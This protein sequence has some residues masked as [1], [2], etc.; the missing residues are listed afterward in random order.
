MKKLIGFSVFFSL[1]IALSSCNER[2]MIPLDQALNAATGQNITVDAKTKIDILFVVDASQSMKKEQESLAENFDTFS[3]FIFE[4]LKNAV[5]YRIAVVSTGQRDE[6]DPFGVFPKDLGAFVNPSLGQRAECQNSTNQILSPTNL[7]CDI[8]DAD[9]QRTQ[10][11]A[12]F[13]C[14]AQVGIEGVGFERGLEAMRSALSCNGL[15]AN[16]LGACC[17]FDKSTDSFV[18][19]PLCRG[20]KDS[21]QPSPEFLRPDAFLVVVFITDEDDCSTFSDANA[22]SPYATC[23]QDY[24]TV[25]DL[26]GS[27]NTAELQAANALIYSAYSN[28]RYCGGN[29]PEACHAAECTNNDGQVFDPVECYFK[30]CSLVL[31]TDSQGR[32]DPSSKEACRRQADKLAPV[33]FYHRFLLGLKERPNDQ[34]IVANIVSPGLLTPSGYRLN[35]SDNAPAAMQCAENAAYLSS[36]L[37]MCCPNGQCGAIPDLVSCPNGDGEEGDGY[38]AWRYIDLMSMFGENGLGCREGE[39]T[40]CVNLCN[41]NLKDALIALRN[42]VIS[43]VGEYCVAGRPACVVTDPTSGEKRACVDVELE[44]SS[45]YQVSLRQVCELGPEDNGDCGIV[46]SETTLN[47]GVDYNLILNDLTCA[48]GI[49]VKLSA[50]PKAGSTTKIDFEQSQQIF[51]Q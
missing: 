4:D 40:N 48:S 51:D 6:S 37:D 39:T 29:N 33:S 3:D 20:Q 31:R 27:G 35:F 46:G 7:G 32:L 13:S 50:P 22:D 30:R 5:D 1:I 47:E 45:N 28:P 17:E 23:S 2:L 43:A 12:Q 38:S 24:K 11:K 41:P 26:Y 10:L 16:Y 18:Y 49:R 19:D 44:V 8:T 15:N 34:I 21:N 14:A 25:K 36:N 9:C 42:K